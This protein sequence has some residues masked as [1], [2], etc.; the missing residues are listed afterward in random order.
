[1]KKLSVVISAYNE[2]KKIEECL[3]SVKFADEI[4]VVDNESTDKTAEIAGKYT[5]KLF[6][7]ENNPKKID[8]QKISVLIRQPVISY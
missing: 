3:K 6:K 7:Q 4:I 2:E 1:M 8:I 5:R